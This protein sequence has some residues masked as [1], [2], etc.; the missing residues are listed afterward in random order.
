MILIPA[1]IKDLRS[2]VCTNSELGSVDGK[3][4]VIAGCT[5]QIGSRECTPFSDLV[6]SES[7]SSSVVPECFGVR[8]SSIHASQEQVYAASTPSE[9][10]PYCLC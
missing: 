9:V 4:S 2:H 8:D 10:L 5:S 6:L 1:S 3:I 7:S